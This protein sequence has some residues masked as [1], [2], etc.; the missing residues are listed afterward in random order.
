MNT[1]LRISL[2]SVALAGSAAADLPLTDPRPALDRPSSY[3]GSAKGLIAQDVSRLKLRAQAYVR[4]DAVTLSDVLIFAEAD[5]RLLAEIGDEPVLAKLAGPTET[6]IDHDQVVH[7]L[8]ELGVNLARVLVSG[9]LSCRVTLEPVAAEAVPS[10]RPPEAPLLRTPLQ[11]HATALADLLRDHVEDELASLGGTAEIEFERAGQEFLE[12][13][14]PPFDFS[15]RSNRGRKLGLREFSVTIRRDG[16]VQRTVRIGGHVKLVRRV[17][18]AAKP[19]NVGAYVKRDS[20][21]YATRIFSDE[22][23]LGLDQPEQIIGQ[24]VKNFVPVGQMVQASDLKAVDLVKR[25]QPVTVIGGDNVSIRIT[26][27]ALDSGSYGD[28]IRVR[29]GDSRKNRREI[30]GVVTGVG[31][32]QLTNNGGL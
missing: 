14:T 15:V 5:P 10:D 24:R 19:L 9:A 25:S 11:E 13:T 29:L 12:L 20:L 8:E 32:V 26:G 27:D 16:R 31:T 21:E 17:L 4:G 3:Q 2:V 1:L 28:T 30:R 22:Q 7:R 6:E 18:V 23:G